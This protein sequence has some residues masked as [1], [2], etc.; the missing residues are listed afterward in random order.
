MVDDD[1]ALVGIITMTDIAKA[2]PQARAD[3][4][5]TPRPATVTPTTPV[6][7]ALE[8]MA[9]LGV[10]RLPVV[11]T[12]DPTRLVGLFRREDAVTAYHRA[13]GSSTD[14]EMHRR[15]LRMR[16]DP[17][18]RYYEFRIPPGSFPDRRTVKEVVWPEGSTLVSIRRGTL[19]LV[20]SGTTELLAGDVVTAFGTEGS[21]RRLR[22]R[23]TAAAED[24]T[25]EVTIEMTALG[26]PI[27]PPPP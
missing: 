7:E 2:S 26:D 14:H 11:D 13:L 18:A 4:V 15:R 21:E 25:V 17:G 10:G 1:G 22:E 8:R 20:P 5:M 9:V 19:V 27:E 12:H 16:T 6:S 23:L 24:P 3:E